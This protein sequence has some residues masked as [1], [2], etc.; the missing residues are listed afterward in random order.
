MYQNCLDEML[1]LLAAAGH[2]NYAKSVQIHLQDL[3]DLETRNPCIYK[4]FS[5]GLFVI[6]KSDRL[7]A[8]LSKDLVIELMLMRTMKVTGG[9]VH[10]RGVMNENQ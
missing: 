1:P 4:M 8:G 9:L 10:G 5:A 6:R 2:N 3:E 7:W